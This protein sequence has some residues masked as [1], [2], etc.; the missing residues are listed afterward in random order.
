MGTRTSSHIHLHHP[1]QTRVNEI[2]RLP[3]VAL[4]ETGNIRKF[5][6]MADALDLI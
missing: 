6:A 3:T 5:V 4:L 2:D 1:G